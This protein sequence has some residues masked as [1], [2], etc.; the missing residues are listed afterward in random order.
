MAR[1]LVH[2]PH[3]RDKDGLYDSICPTCFATVARSK[4]EAEMVEL[5]LAHVCNSSYLAERGH[6]SR[7]ESQPQAAPLRRHTDVLADSTPCCNT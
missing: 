7:P 3:R 4:P 5:E 2:F 6:F 1:K